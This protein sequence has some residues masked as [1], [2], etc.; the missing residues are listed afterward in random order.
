M[1]ALIKEEN[2]W[3]E[4]TPPDCPQL[5]GCSERFN[6]SIITKCR[7]MLL[8]SGLPLE[9]WEMSILQA[10][11]IYNA[12]PHKTVGMKIT[13]ALFQRKSVDIKFLKRFGSVVYRLIP[14]TKQ[15]TEKFESNGQKCLI[16]GTRPNS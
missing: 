5:N 13:Y 1:K 4:V 8:D 14:R 7:A 15:V 9:F 11:R 10:A 3:P 2:I 16:L 6:L 12:L